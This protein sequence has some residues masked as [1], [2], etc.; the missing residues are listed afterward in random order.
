MQFKQLFF[1]IIPFF[2]AGCGGGGGDPEGA[3]DAVDDSG[4]V[5][6]ITSA[7]TFSVLE[8]RTVIATMSASK[9]VSW[10]VS[11]TDSAWIAIDPTWGYLSFKAAGDYEVPVDDGKNNT[12]VVTIKAQ[13]GAVGSSE[14]VTKEVTV[15]VT[16]DSTERGS[17]VTDSTFNPFER[18]LD[19]RKLRLFV[20]TG[21]SNTFMESIASAYEAMLMNTTAIDYDLRDGL[22]T[23]L[24][25]LNAYQR[26]GY[27]GPSNYSGSLDAQ[28]GGSY[29]DSAI[30]YI[31]EQTGS[32]E[33]DIIGE[34]I[35]HLLHTITAIGFNTSFN[36][37]W[38]WNSTSSQLHLAMQQ[39]I[40]NGVYDVS[41]YEDK[42][43]DTE[44]Y[45]KITATEYAYWLILAEWDY[46]D[47]AGKV[48][49][50]YGTG[51]SEFNVGTSAEIQT[52]NP[53]G[54]RLYVDTV[55]KILSVPDKDEIRSL[56]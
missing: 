32:S 41:S 39:A 5:L 36:S 47:V 21:V 23:A 34:V 14:S 18:Y 40:S 20:R 8:N 2:I 50:G 12:Y 29:T 48:E 44:A 1:L 33:A 54:H 26:I 13:D 38:T 31:W 46:F 52:K 51:N 27:I 49:S 55:A 30:D 37:E 7:S 22:F 53:L 35:E 45:N 16:N 11:G 19:V 6:A 25:T 3:A 4:A 28:P 56:F 10:S 43:S 24:N 15:T 42:K 17:I 9:G